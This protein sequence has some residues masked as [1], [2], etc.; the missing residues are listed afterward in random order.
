M[1]RDPAFLF[2]DGDAARDVSHMNRLER[3][4]YFDIIQMQRKC[5]GIA[6][7]KIGKVLG[8]DFD[9]CWPAL[10]I[11]LSN[12]ESGYFIPWVRESIE[13]RARHCE[14]QRENANQRW[15]KS[16]LPTQCHG[17]TMG[18]PLEDENEIEN[19][20]VTEPTKESNKPVKVIYPIDEVIEYLNEKAG[21]N[22]GLK[23][24]ANRKPIKARF[25]E[26]RTLDNFKVV[27]D[28]KLSEWSGTD[29]EKFLRP[30]TLFGNKFEGYLN[31][32][33]ISKT[34]KPVSDLFKSSMALNQ[35]KELS[36][37]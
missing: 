33:V 29:Y 12:D 10:E 34:G 36:N 4:A 16:D 24:E 20:A 22:Y 6:K 11:V 3:G 23:I 18:M 13:K 32:P 14:K 5:H 25:E 37:V 15:H 35:K 7:D 26:G 28:K 8:K 9:A 2:Y 17:N 1:S 31:Q 30:E 19:E 27:I 21:K